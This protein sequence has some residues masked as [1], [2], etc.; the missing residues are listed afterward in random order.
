M[1]ID[2]VLKLYSE[3]IQSPYLH[4][5]FWDN[6]ETINSNVLS[7]DDIVKAQG[8]YIEHLSSFIPE[9]VKKI[10]DVGCGVGG[11]AEYLKEK[12]FEIDVLSPDTYQEEFIN[13]KFNGDMRFYKTKFEDFN[14]NTIYDLILESESACYIKINE[15][16]S[17]ARE[18]LRLGG[19]LL[20]SDYFVHF[21]DG[22]KSPH[23]KSS[24][25][26]EGYLSSASA[27]GFKLLEFVDLSKLKTLIFVSSNA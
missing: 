4:Y 23:L 2:H 16:F 24:H 17:K 13:N 6:P 12:G 22:S 25:D 1:A 19:Y 21:K 9:D 18:V 14:S 20:A 3:T 11:N 7:I 5:G 26:I 15:G 27:N 8:R 10:I